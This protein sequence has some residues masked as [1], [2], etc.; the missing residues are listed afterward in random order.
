MLVWLRCVVL[1]MLATWTMAAAAAEKVLV[2]TYYDFPPFVEA[3]GDGL[4]KQLCTL[5]ENASGGRYQFELQVVPRLRFDAMLERTGTPILAP[6]VAPEFFPNAARYRWGRALMDDNAVML[7][8]PG[9]AVE[10][11]QM[12]SLRGLRFGGVLGHHYPFGALENAIKQGYVSRAD[13][14]SPEQNYQNLVLGRIDM[15]IM[16]ES[17]L[18]YLTQRDFAALRGK[19][20]PT[21]TTLV[22]TAVHRSYFTLNADGALADFLAREMDGLRIVK[23][24]KPAW[25]ITTKK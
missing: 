21:G 6:W 15:T 10:L 19:T 13:N 14:A 24:E 16:A 18:H 2:L 5:L 11:E 3:N 25:L 17:T 23:G 1:W 20:L 8:M 9:K 22:S 12:E 7:A 4:S